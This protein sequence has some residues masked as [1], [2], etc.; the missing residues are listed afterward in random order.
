MAK[1]DTVPPEQIE[2]TWGTCL[3][4]MGCY[5]VDDLNVAIERYKDQKNA[6]TVP[7]VG[8][9]EPLQTIVPFI[10]QIEHFTMLESQLSGQILTDILSS[11][12][13]HTVEAEN[14]RLYLINECGD[15]LFNLMFHFDGIRL[16]TI[17]VDLDMEYFTTE[18]LIKAWE[19]C[20]EAQENRLE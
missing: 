13:F 20:K 5:N 4:D 3:G 9:P 12:S 11:L 6:R 10:K 7:M 18:S 8:V 15:G 2:M 14:R 19:A 17:K 1:T 16:Y